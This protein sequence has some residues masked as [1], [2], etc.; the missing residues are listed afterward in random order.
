MEKGNNNKYV[1]FIS[2]HSKS[3]MM[4]LQIVAGFY[5]LCK[6]LSYADIFLYSMIGLSIFMFIKK[7]LNLE[8]NLK[9][10]AKQDFALIIE[11][12]VKYYKSIIEG[13]IDIDN[14]VHLFEV[15][16]KIFINF[17]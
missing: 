5:L 17:L 7:N 13:I 3:V 12:C 6:K 8:H 4:S 14:L 16:I 2:S 15:R 1:E 11:D 9:L 10:N